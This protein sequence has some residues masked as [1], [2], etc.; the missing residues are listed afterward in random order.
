MRM[1]ARTLD[2]RIFIGQLLFQKLRDY[3]MVLKKIYYRRV[4]I[5]GKCL[6]CLAESSSYG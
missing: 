3:C 5:I 4:K 6:F 2:A 1:H